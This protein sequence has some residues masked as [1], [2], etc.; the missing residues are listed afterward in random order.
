M[1]F[2]RGGVRAGWIG[3]AA[4]LVA[5]LVIVLA[6]P[7]AAQRASVLRAQT[8]AITGAISRQVQHAMRPKLQIRNG[9]GPI[10]HLEMGADGRSMVISSADFQVRVWDLETGRQTRNLPL[11]SATLVGGLDVG[12][13]PVPAPAPVKGAAKSRAAVPAGPG[14]RAVVT[15]AADGTV[16]LYDAVAGVMIRQFRDKGPVLAIRLAPG[17]AVLATAGADY[18]INLWEVA[19]GRKIAELKGHSDAVTELAFSVSGR[20]LAS[21]GSDGSVRLWSVAG[22]SPITTLK[23]DGKVSALAFSG[24]ERLVAGT[25]EG[26][27]Y[28]WSA[29]GAPLGSWQAESGAVT[30]LS[31]N[32]SGTVIT[33]G[34]DDEA[35]LWNSSGSSIGRISDTDNRIV[36]ATFSPDGTRAIT[37]GK[38]G[39]ARVWD[40]SSGTF[41]AQM[42]L[43]TTGW[44]VTDANGRFDGSEGGLGN[45]SWAA[46]EGVFDISNF[47]ESHFEP[48]LLA[49]VLRAPNAIITAAA[50]SVEVGVGVPPSVTVT[51]PSGTSAASGPATVTVTAVEQGGGIDQVRLFQNEKAVDPGRVASDSGQGQSPRTVTYNVELSGGTNN[52]RAVATSV[53]HIEGLPALL[54]VRVA[55]AER[56]PTLHL[57]TVGINQYANPQMTLNYAVADAKGFVDWAKKQVNP[58]FAKIEVHTLFDRAATRASILDQ[59]AALK[60]TKPEDV[61]II[62]LA[63][64]GENANDN[65]YFL[66]TEFGRTM[67]LAAVAGEGVSAQM[68]EDGILKLGAERVLMLIDACKSGSLSKAFAADAD[69]KALQLVSRTAGI[70]VL[71]ATDKDQLAVELAELGHGAFTYTVLQGLAGRASTDSVVRAKG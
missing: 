47:S 68:L 31:I 56:Q 35:H 54:S 30:G 32:R 4:V 55:T 38:N 61:V 25:S 57:I 21:G 28:V 53:E 43:T 41:L 12:S 2:K 34:G 40:T 11:G 44:A 7:A 27:V 48:G 24:D 65:W 62:Y 18:T 19:T 42:I 23:G 59:L 70:H 66:P 5:M 15:A 60:T 1:R 45:V 50:P 49:K 29:T 10:H 13:I 33:A 51:S 58:D 22:A 37:A 36:F 69:R 52:F 6:G 26:M 67:S 16:T 39:R 71:A 8:H 14:L 9:A 3:T 20:T 46:D 17:G 64:H 63:G